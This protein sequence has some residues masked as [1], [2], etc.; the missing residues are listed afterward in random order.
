MR[1]TTT[2]PSEVSGCKDPEEARGV[3]VVEYQLQA[4]KVRRTYVTCAEPHLCTEAEAAAHNVAIPIVPGWQRLLDKGW[5]KV[6]GVWLCP[7][8]AAEH[9]SR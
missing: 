4:G 9:N 7:E 2:S 3:A 6:R 1:L 8:C 5:A